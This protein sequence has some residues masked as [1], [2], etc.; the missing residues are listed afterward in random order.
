MALLSMKIKYDQMLPGVVDGWDWVLVAVEFPM[1]MEVLDP[2]GWVEDMLGAVVAAPVVVVVVGRRVV[3][4]PFVP[5]KLS[6]VAALTTT[7][8]ARRSIVVSFV[9]NEKGDALSIFGRVL[10]VPDKSAVAEVQTLGGLV[11][12]MWPETWPCTLLTH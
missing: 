1:C 5:A 7:I 4:W 3:V 2:A 11:V 10:C 9:V 12:L 6:P 8:R